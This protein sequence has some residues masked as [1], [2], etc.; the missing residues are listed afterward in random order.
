MSKA[1]NQ[2][3]ETKRNEAMYYIHIEQDVATVS[4]THFLCGFLR[5][6]DLN[7]CIIWKL[8]RSHAR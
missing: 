5:L 8:A 1:H 2:F 7:W 3:N 4:G 6:I